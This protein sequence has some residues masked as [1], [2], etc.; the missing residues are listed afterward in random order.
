MHG[1]NTSHNIINEAHAGNIEPKSPQRR[2]PAHDRIHDSVF[3]PTTALSRLHSLSIECLHTYN[4]VNRMLSIMKPSAAVMK[5]SQNPISHS[6]PAPGINH[7]SNDP[8]SYV[9]VELFLPLYL[10]P[11]LLQLM[12]YLTLVFMWN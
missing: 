5:Q 11:V 10:L 3:Q 12:Q 6:S 9:Y 4:H 7:D 2:Y 8:P 1:I